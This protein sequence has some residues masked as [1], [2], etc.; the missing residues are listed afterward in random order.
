MTANIMF[1]VQNRYKVGVGPDGIAADSRIFSTKAAAEAYIA[2]L[3]INGSPGWV[4]SE[5]LFEGWATSELRETSRCERREK[6][7]QI[8]DNTLGH[9]SDVRAHNGNDEAYFSALDGVRSL[10]NQLLALLSRW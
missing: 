7:E 10:R 4:I 6:I 2:T 9:I 1:I 8:A 3:Q 5:V